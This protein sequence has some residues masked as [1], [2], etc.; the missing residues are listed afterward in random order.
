MRRILMICFVFL[1]VQG[2]LLLAIAHAQ[3]SAAGSG[4]EDILLGRNGWEWDGVCISNKKDRGGQGSY[5][6]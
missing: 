5:P 1:A 4:P 6:S 3:F 2:A